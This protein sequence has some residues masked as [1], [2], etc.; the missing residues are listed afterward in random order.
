MLHFNEI[1]NDIA[2]GYAYMEYEGEFANWNYVIV[3]E[4]PAS[5][6]DMLMF[7]FENEEYVAT[8]ALDI[9]EFL[10]MNELQFVNFANEAIYYHTIPNRMYQ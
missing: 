10:N 1:K 4:K 6:Y 9:N 7:Q 2:N 8:F 5:G 3:L